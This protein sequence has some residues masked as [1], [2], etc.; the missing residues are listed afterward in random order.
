MI[1]KNENGYTLLLTLAI[2]LIITSFIG[3]LSFLTLNQQTQVEKTD[4]DFLLSDLTEMGIEYYRSRV[5]EDYVR[6]IKEVREKIDRE[7]TNS[8]ELYNTTD[9]VEKLEKD[10]EDIGIRTL[11]TI[12]SS[13]NVNSIAIEQSDSLIFSLIESPYEFESTETYIQFKFL[14]AGSNSVNQEKYSF[15]IRLPKNLVDMTVTNNPGNGSG[16]IDYSK[17]I[18]APVFTPPIG[19]DNCNENYTNTPCIND[20]DK[21]KEAIKDILNST[22]YFIGDTVANSANNTDFKE[23][24][25]I[26]NGD[27]D[28]KNF[29]TIKNVSIFVNGD[30]SIDQLNAYSLK[31][32]SSGKLELNKHITIND[33]N[34]RVLGAVFATKKGMTISNTHMVLEGV[35]NTIDPFIIKN[36]STVCI[37]N[38]SSL[39]ELYIDSTSSVF[40]LNTANRSGQN[41]NGSKLPLSLDIDT[42]NKNCYGESNS[43]GGINVE[44]GE[45]VKFTPESILNEIDYNNTD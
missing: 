7:L 13:Y 12:L 16:T 19:T 20:S 44:F 4:E 30:T 6:V 24:L 27:L 40:I 21:K 14:I 2:I 45:Q 36:S 42:F 39:D 3:T 35:N 18:K 34:I 28:A 33:S 9:K 29:N 43:I 17:T 5:F 25:L 26:I 1:H 10:E 32:F 38:N 11:I 23:S 31:L 8:P 41:S 15:T 22:V 37:K